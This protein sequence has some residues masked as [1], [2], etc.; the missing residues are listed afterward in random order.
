M[1]F[2]GRDFFFFLLP[3]FRKTLLLELLKRNC[4]LTMGIKLPFLSA[5]YLF[6]IK[7]H[8]GFGS[9]KSLCLKFVRLQK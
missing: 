2:D 5:T 9:D 1:P 6:Y 7:V 3:G 8:N 4:L